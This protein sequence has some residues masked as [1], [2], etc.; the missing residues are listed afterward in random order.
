MD[1]S[2]LDKKY[3]IDEYK[4]NCPFCMRNNVVYTLS[5]TIDFDWSE[6]K[7]CYAYKVTCSSCEEDSLHFSYEDIRLAFTD[8]SHANRFKSG[9][10]IDSKMFFSQPSS[11]FSLDNNIPNKIRELVFEAEKA[12]QA[13]LLVGA[14]ACIRKAIYELLVYEK[15][16]IKDSS[17]E[18]ANYQE[19]I[20]NL[21]MKFPSVAS[22]LFDALGDIQEMVSDN[23]HEGSWEAW[24]SPKLKFLIELA[25]TTLHE[26][27]VVP[28][29][30]KT[31]LGVLTQMK[32]V[33]ANSKKT[34]KIESVVKKS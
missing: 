26:I 14:S 16:I 9:I 7:K 11:F 3:F 13:N 23:V 21:K 12:R 25:K 29:E 4:Y 30:R 18:R 10:N 22:E 31:R 33:F 2:A 32:S 5:N 24:D 15:A 28:V 6:H 34:E 19:S 20:K 27:Y 1:L 8:G 17:T